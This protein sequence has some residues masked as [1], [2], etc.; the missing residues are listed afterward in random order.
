[1]AWR[2]IVRNLRRSSITI[3]AISL[4]LAS[5]LFLW[6]FQDGVQNTMTRN[7]QQVVV[8]S[9]Q[10][11]SKGFF[12]QPAL[13][14]ALADR[15][16][17]EQELERLGV[18]RST[19]RLNAFALAAGQGSSE[20]LNMM[21]ISPE[22][23]RL[24]TKLHSKVSLGRFLQKDDT[25][26]CVLGATTASNLGLSLNDDVVLLAN[27]RFGSLSA[28]RFRLVGIIESGEMG[29]DRGLVIVPLTSMQTLL[30]MED[31]ITD[32]VIQLPRTQLEP[33]TSAL[34]TAL[35][36]ERYEVLRWYDMYPVMKQSIE[37]DT[38]FHYIIQAIVL[39]IVAAG[40]M[41]TMLM[42]TMERV[43]EFGVMMA[44]GCSRTRL[45]TMVTIESVL[46]GLVGIMF[47]TLL[48]LGLV[49]FFGRVG[50]N[51][52]QF[53]DTAT[54]FYIDP[55]VHT[56]IN[57]DHLL[58]TVWAVVIAA[59]LAAI[60]PALRAAHLQPVEAIHHV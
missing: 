18:V 52:S 59:S 55:V 8:G 19:V 26:A 34:R 1:M 38:V 14:G 42:S 31:R 58:F 43:H 45:A 27:D 6:G 13:E 22:T 15:A 40:I 16:L 49:A 9:I 39:F 44:L 7:L 33:T 17:V 11:H 21:G 48:G 51:L 37:R 32:I 5:L 12:R 36:P 20:G 54:R 10:I 60:V 23:E 30:G 3:S 2:N 25:N 53:I 46:I 29:I 28:E 50:I 56:E 35:D 41:N 47:G 57:M 4:G 24:T